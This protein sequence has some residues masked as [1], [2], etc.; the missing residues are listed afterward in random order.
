VRIDCKLS[1]R[2]VFGTRSVRHAAAACLAV[3]LLFAPTPPVRASAN[4]NLDLPSGQ[5]Q[6]I[7]VPG[8]SGPVGALAETLSAACREDS[9]AFA[10]R[11]T[12]PNGTA[13]R[14]LPQSQQTALLKRMVLLDQPGRPLLSTDATGQTQMRCEAGGV[15]AVMRL[16]AAQTRENLSFIVV[17]VLPPRVTPQPGGRAEAPDDS[18]NTRTVR[19]GLVREGSDWK[20]LSL[21]LVLIDIP[22]LAQ[23][24]QLADAESRETTAIAAIRTIAAA[25]K[26]YQEAFGRLPEVLEQLGPAEKDALSP[27]HAGLLN[28]RL[29]AGESGGY[30]FRYS[31]IPASDDADESERE[32]S[33]G[34][35]LAATP[36][37]YG[38]DGRRS[39]YLDSHG[40]LKGADKRGQVANSKDPLIDDSAGRGTP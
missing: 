39:F 36:M 21:G 27:D 15:V 18:E 13:F 7:S 40:G 11:L 35:A 5:P 22:T 23:Q 9:D 32:K 37:K 25:L 3:L 26:M 33:A 1:A 4:A 20:L 19:F 24:W 2:E 14:D 10:G 8:T 17:D 28:A 30:T 12:A 29:A 6:Q 38:E 34:F 31:I 16:G